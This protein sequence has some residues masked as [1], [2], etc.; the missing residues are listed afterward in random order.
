MFPENP[1]P[2]LNTRTFHILLSLLSLGWIACSG[3]QPQAAPETARIL[4]QG[5]V[6][7][8]SL[9]AGQVH[10][11]RGLPFAKAP[12]ES[13]RWRSPEPAEGWRASVAPLSQALPVRSSAGIL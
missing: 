12:V 5:E 8:T 10:A 7:G 4:S 13:L 2:F 3:D 9:E 6:V 11:W 1:V